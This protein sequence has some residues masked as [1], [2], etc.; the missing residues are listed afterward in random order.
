MLDRTDGTIRIQPIELP[1][2]AQVQNLFA[3]TN[4]YDLWIGRIDAIPGYENE[5][6]L[7]KYTPKI[8]RQGGRPRFILSAQRNAGERYLMRASFT[9]IGGIPLPGGWTFPLDPDPLFF[10]SPVLFG[11]SGSGVLD[12]SGTAIVDLQLPLGT[13]SQL[14]FFTAF[15]A[16]T[17]RIRAVSPAYLFR[18]P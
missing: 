13:P 2:Y 16:H 15:L 7:R 8:V 14:E 4:G 18:T 6:Y 1:N 17:D 12:Q 3:S 5:I 11:S 10:L 9:A